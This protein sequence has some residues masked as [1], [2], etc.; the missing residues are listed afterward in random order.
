MAA[1]AVGHTIS[2]MVEQV[3]STQ[4][5]GHTT[6]YS[7]AH[8]SVNSKDYNPCT[9]CKTVGVFGI[10]ECGMRMDLWMYYSS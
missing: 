8:A 6:E 10:S 7:A 9:K 1:A 3:A 5:E 2:S 4:G